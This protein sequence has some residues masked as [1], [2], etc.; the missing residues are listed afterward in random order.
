MEIEALE[1]ANKS[2]HSEMQEISL[3][4][5]KLHELNVQ[6]LTEKKVLETELQSLHV[7]GNIKINSSNN[8][9]NNI[10]IK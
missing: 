7:G 3:K 2:L 4:S 9:N 8:N 1:R 10:N 5:E 6:L